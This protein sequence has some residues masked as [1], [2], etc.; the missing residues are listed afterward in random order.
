[1]A[2]ADGFLADGDLPEQIHAELILHM[3]TLHHSMYTSNREFR[4]RLRRYNYV[5]P[6]NFLDYIT[7]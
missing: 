3:L 6:K 1:M 4:T 5:T 2:A 7:K